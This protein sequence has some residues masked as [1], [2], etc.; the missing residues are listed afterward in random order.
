[1]EGACLSVREI[2]TYTSFLFEDAN[3]HHKAF[4][5]DYNVV[6]SAAAASKRRSSTIVSIPRRRSCDS[7][8]QCTRGRQPDRHYA[9]CP[10]QMQEAQRID[11]GPRLSNGLTTP[12]EWHCSTKC[13]KLRRRR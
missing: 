2:A 10:V 8:M 3:A 4:F 11:S 7:W 12:G 1:M 5:V 6:N 13:N 9:V